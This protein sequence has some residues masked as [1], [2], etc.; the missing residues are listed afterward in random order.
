MSLREE[1][2]RGRG[3]GRGRR[4]EPSRAGEA[5]ARRV[6]RR[7]KQRSDA[8]GGHLWGRGH[9]RDPAPGSREDR[10]R[11]R[12]RHAGE[13]PRGP[14]PPGLDSP[15]TVF[16]LKS[17]AMVRGRA[18][19]ARLRPVPPAAGRGQE[20][21]LGPADGPLRRRGEGQAARAGLRAGPRRAGV[22]KPPAAEAPELR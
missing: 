2:G 5:G 13:A 1:D 19:A 22:A 12:P 6:P 16:F 10:G 20:G 15:S 8:R 14:L 18:R 11:K 17:D 4:P 3:R 7:G 9:G 21:G